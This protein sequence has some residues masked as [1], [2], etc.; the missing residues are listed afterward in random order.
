MQ[1]YRIMNKNYSYGRNHNFRFTNET[2][3][4]IKDNFKSEGY[5]Y[6]DQDELLAKAVAGD[7][8]AKNSIVRCNFGLVLDALDSVLATC[9]YSAMHHDDLL[10]TA[11]FEL[12]RCLVSFDPSQGKFS[13][14]AYKC[15]LFAI[16]KQITV[17][18]I[19]EPNED[20]TFGCNET[21]GVDA[22]SEEC[23]ER[24]FIMQIS[25]VLDGALSPEEAK[26]IR[27]RYGLEDGREYKT[28]EIGR[29]FGCTDSYIGKRIKR[30]IEEIRRYIEENGI[31]FGFGR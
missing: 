30:D 5:S 18:D 9:K 23:E 4:F 7:E 15:I 2:W 25:S 6:K 20:I 11:L 13:S 3:Q 31:D 16:R 12:S 19:E 28:A 22:T 14:Y 8:D 27:L 17:P 24:E 1:E 26:I 10:Q 29:I 21:I